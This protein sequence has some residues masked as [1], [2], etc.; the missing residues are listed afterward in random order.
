[1]RGF[2]FGSCSVRNSRGSSA[3]HALFARAQRTC[4]QHCLHSWDAESE[5]D[6][7]RSWHAQSKTDCVHSWNAQSKTDSV[8][9]GDAESQAEYVHSWDAEPE[10]DCVGVMSR[11]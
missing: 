11:E 1:M 2:W 9:S 10:A 5:A 8:R 6:Y 7:V 4:Y 3:I